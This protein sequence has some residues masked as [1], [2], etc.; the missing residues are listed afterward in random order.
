MH[1]ERWISC[2]VLRYMREWL[3]CWIYRIRFD[4]DDCHTCE[5]WF[6]RA[7]R[8]AIASLSGIDLLYCVMFYCIVGWYTSYHTLRICQRRNQ[9]GSPRGLFLGDIHGIFRQSPWS[10]G[11]TT[12]HRHHYVMFELLQRAYQ[13]TMI[14]TYRLHMADND[15]K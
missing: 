14:F 3:Y 11:S 6:C 4:D 2:M 10:L 1:E 13:Y 8:K 5:R 7:V 12:I 9:A 15:G